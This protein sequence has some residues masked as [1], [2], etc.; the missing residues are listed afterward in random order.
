[1]AA[2]A[3]TL[4][5]L[6]PGRV[7]LG[8]GAG[9]TF[10]EWEVTGRQRPSASDRAARLAEFVDAVARLLDGETVTA[11]GRHVSL[12][13]ARL[14]DLPACGRIGLVVGGANPEILRVGAARAEV[15]ALSGLGRTLP[16]GHRHEVRWKSNDLRAQLRLI[17]EESERC[18][19][20]PEIEV[21][22]QQVRVTE[23]RRQV[24]AELS[25]GRRGVSV[26]DL[27]ETP[28][29][30]VGTL[31]QMAAQLVRQAEQLGITRYVV[32]GSAVEP[33][34]QVLSQLNSR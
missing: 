25:E 20:M 32:R 11:T 23:N 24:L 14:E 8:L 22:V 31:P 16:D 30:M 7:L 21:L 4:D 15:V 13:E 27:A 12:V 17:H 19:T 3:A 1:M 26:D 18:G 33:V 34:E 28:F 5:V 9:H 6:A 10:R 29:V 2:D